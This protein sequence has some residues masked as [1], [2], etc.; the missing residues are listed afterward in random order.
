MHF[1]YTEYDLLR[2]LLMR[3]SANGL[4]KYRLFGVLVC[5]ILSASGLDW[6]V[7]KSS[8]FAI[9]RACLLRRVRGVLR[10]HITGGPALWQIN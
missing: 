10:I 1:N 6:L 8:G 3:I 4:R 9:L 2:F 5:G 7:D